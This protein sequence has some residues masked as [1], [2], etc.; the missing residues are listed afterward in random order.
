MNTTGP[1]SRRVGEK[2]FFVLS[3]AL[4]L[5]LMADISGLRYTNGT[6]NFFIDTLQI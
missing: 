2:S 6:L 4:R 3:T 1:K 5:A